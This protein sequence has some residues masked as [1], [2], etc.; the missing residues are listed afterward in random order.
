V[1]YA[2]PSNRWRPFVVPR[3]S[4]AHLVLVLR[5]LRDPPAAELGRLLALWTN[6][7]AACS[8]DR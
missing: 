4:L 6:T 7:R 1:A 5:I 8:A 3:G 2:T